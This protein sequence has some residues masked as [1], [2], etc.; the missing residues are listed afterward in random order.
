MG[1]E[2]YRRT[3]GPYTDRGSCSNLQAVLGILMQIGVDVCQPRHINCS[4]TSVELHI[5]E[6]QNIVDNHP[7]SVLLRWQKPGGRYSC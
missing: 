1:C 6:K 2:Q 3:E 7:I 4:V 5:P